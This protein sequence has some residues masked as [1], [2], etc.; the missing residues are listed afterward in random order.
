MPAKSQGDSEPQKTSY[1]EDNLLA[2]INNLSG[3]GSKLTSRELEFYKKKLDSNIANILQN[4]HTK[5]VLSQILDEKD[6]QVAVRTIKHWM[7][8]DTTIS[9]WCPAFLKLFENGLWVVHNIITFIQDE[10]HYLF[11]L[12]C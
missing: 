8:T 4:D 1:S 7:I 9:N 3:L 10:V 11:F 5:A 12:F 2:K 6:K